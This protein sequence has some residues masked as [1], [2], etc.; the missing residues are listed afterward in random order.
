MEKLAK[1]VSKWDKQIY[2]FNDPANTRL[3]ELGIL[4]SSNLS[5]GNFV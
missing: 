4:L 2:T 5:F 3:L 1:T